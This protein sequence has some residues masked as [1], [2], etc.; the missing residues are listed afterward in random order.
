MVKSLKEKL[1]QVMQ[2]QENKLLLST[3]DEVG[4]CRKQSL[5]ECEVPYITAT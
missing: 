3:A 4:E 2:K 5:A 1:N